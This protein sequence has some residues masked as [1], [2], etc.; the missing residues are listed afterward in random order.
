MGARD[1]Q[2]IKDDKVKRI[3]GIFDEDNKIHQ[4]G[5]IY[6]TSGISPTVTSASGGQACYTKTYFRTL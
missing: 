5:S 3:V 4:A 1:Q 2:Y 6:D